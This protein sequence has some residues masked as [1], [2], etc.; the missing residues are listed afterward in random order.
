MAL[1]TSG[2]SSRDRLLVAFFLA[3]MIG[4]G[5]SLSSLQAS[6]AERAIAQTRQESQSVASEMVSAQTF[7]SFPGRVHHASFV[8]AINTPNK[9]CLEWYQE[10][11][12]AAFIEAQQISDSSHRLIQK[13]ALRVDSLPHHFLT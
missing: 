5:L 6:R 3:A 12:D 4:L 10:R 9:V 7:D 11:R 8:I 13:W 1:R 2:G